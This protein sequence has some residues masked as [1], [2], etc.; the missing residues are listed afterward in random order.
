MRTGAWGLKMGQCANYLCRIPFL[1]PLLTLLLSNR[2][3]VQYG[4]RKTAVF[5]HDGHHAQRMDNGCLHDC[6]D[7]VWYATLSSMNA[8]LLNDGAGY[9][10]GVFG[11]IIVT[12]D[13]LQTMGNPNPNLQGT[14]VSLYD[15][16]WC[17]MS[18]RI[19]EHDIKDILLI[20][21][22]ARCLPSSLENALAARRP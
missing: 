1:R 11:G 2:D 19:F 18:S 6:Y 12:P 7:T 17:A 8:L 20:A 13:F 5:R 3:I 4:R 22:S 21:S 10:Q 14:I 15:I 16:G 9:D